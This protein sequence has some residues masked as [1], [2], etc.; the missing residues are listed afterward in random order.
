[1]TAPDDR[2]LFLFGL[3]LPA[4]RVGLAYLTLWKIA[5]RAYADVLF[6]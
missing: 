3:R 1:M 4:Y 2:G 6:H 5:V